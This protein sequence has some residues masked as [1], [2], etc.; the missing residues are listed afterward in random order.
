MLGRSGRIR[1]RI[2]AFLMF[3]SASVLGQTVGTLTVA[4]GGVDLV[5][6]TTAYTAA[7]GVRLQNGDMLAVGLKGQAQ[8]EFEDGAILNL[9]RGSRA[10]LLAAQG[11][12]TEPG[13]A[14][15]SGWAKFTRTKA[16]KGKPYRYVTPLAR[17]STTGATGVLRMG[18]DTSELF[19]ESGTGRFVELSAA[20]APAGGRDVKGGEFVVRRAAQPVTVSARPSADFVKAMPGHFKDDLPAFLP[21]V[22]N[23][24]VEPTREHEA[25]YAEVEVWLKASLPIRRNL[26]ERFQGRAKDGQFRSK[27]IE[28]LAAHPEWDRI[29]FPEKYEEE[30]EKAGKEK[31]K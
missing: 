8:I 10:L 31:G 2:A 16:A 25:T 15:K 6:G 1:L 5:R 13:V 9:T 20:G 23:K 21:R 26:A 22:R 11:A 19:I 27:L 7:Q 14:L 24:N 17:L 29:L 28:N 18:D 30:S 3:S 4:E 12:N